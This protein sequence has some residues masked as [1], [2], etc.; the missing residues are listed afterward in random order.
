[1]EKSLLVRRR[2]ESAICEFCGKEFL[3][4]VKS[5]KRFKQRFC[6]VECRKAGRSTVLSKAKTDEVLSLHLNGRSAHEIV[7]LLGISRWH[8]EKALGDKY[9]P[10]KHSALDDKYIP[11]KHFVSEANRAEIESLYKNG[12]SMAMIV[13]QTGRSYATV[14]KTLSG[15]TRNASQAA[16]MAIAQGRRVLTEESRQLIGERSRKSIRNARTM[17]TKPEQEFK[18][19][20]N[21]IGIGVCFPDFA[22]DIF[23]VK[24]D[25]SPDVLFQYPIGVYVCDFVDHIHNVIFRVHGDFWHANP[26]LYDQE[27]LTKIQEKNV[28]HDKMGRQYLEKKGYLVCDV[29]ESEIKWNKELVISKI[30]AAR[31]AANPPAR[32]AGLAQFDS[33]AAHQEWQKTVRSIWFK[34]HRPKRSKIEKYCPVC[35][36]KFDVVQSKSE[37]RYC[38]T[39]CSGQMQRK[40]LRPS[41]EALEEEIKHISLTEIAKKNGIS[42]GAVRKWVISY[43]LHMP[44]R[45]RILETKCAQCSRKYKPKDRQQEFC[46]RKCSSE[47]S[48]K[49]KRPTFDI[50]LEMRKTKTLKQI[51]EQY[52]V[53]GCTVRG[54]VKESDAQRLA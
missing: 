34:P 22:K 14:M 44:I 6:C 8:V 54:W 1:M 24:D 5:S 49:A 36:V 15:K 25:P 51:G 38:S 7:H 3:R 2:S 31:E 30:R 48:R 19:V 21:S 37:A 33:E 20:L 45:S 28:H 43:G 18:D 53:A 39:K 12:Y 29:W 4:R 26:L 42:L 17:W 41:K 13:K 9:V 27:K 52:G 50:L 32:H 16:K 40:V 47:A 11:Y 35:G 10:Y 23:G 46:S